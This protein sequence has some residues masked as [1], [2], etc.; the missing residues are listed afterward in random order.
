MAQAR[1]G[2]RAFDPLMG[3]RAGQDVVGREQHVAYADAHVAR[4]VARRVDDPQAVQLVAVFQRPSDRNPFEQPS[5]VGRYFQQIGAAGRVHSRPVQEGAQ[6]ADAHHGM[7]AGRSDGPAIQRM[8]RHF[9]RHLP[10]QFGQAPDVVHVAVADQDAADVSR[11]DVL[12]ELAMDGLDAGK[13]LA[14]RRLQAAAGIDQRGRP[15]PEQQVDAGRK[16]LEDLARNLVDSHAEIGEE[17][18]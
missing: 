12:A 4:R 9:G 15:R 16:R 1:V 11:A 18:S 5:A 2:R 14:D 8:N 7:L 3:Q 17:S 10:Q 6:S 13:N